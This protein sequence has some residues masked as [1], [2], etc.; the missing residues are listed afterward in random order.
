MH[1]L[2]IKS[3]VAFV[4]T[5]SS[6]K[7]ENPISSAR[8]AFEKK[9]TASLKENVNNLLSIA[10]SDI[11]EY[12]GFIKELDDLHKKEFQQVFDSLKTRLNKNN[13]DL[14]ESSDEEN[15]FVDKD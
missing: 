5:C 4:P 1:T 12:S 10:N 9:R 3:R 8:K 6:A 11:K 14:K 7:K 2:T 15:I 13:A